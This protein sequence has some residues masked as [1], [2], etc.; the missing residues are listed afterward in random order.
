MASLSAIG[1]D[2]PTDIS[3]PKCVS[4]C[5]T[6]ISIKTKQ[7]PL[8]FA[9]KSVASRQFYHENVETS[10]LPKTHKGNDIGPQ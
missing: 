5:T 1:R 3:A 10:N 9:L 6:A 2:V 7:S 8:S 4:E